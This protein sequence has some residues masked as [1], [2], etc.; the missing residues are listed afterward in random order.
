[1]LWLAILFALVA[2]L[3]ALVGFGGG[4]SYNALLI[5]AEVDYRLIPITALLCN[6]VV[7]SGGVFHFHRAGHLA[8]PTVVPFIVSSIPMSVLGGWLPISESHFIVILGLALMISGV[9]MLLPRT[10]LTRTEPGLRQRW[11]LGIPLGAGLGLLAGMVG[12][13]GGIFLAPMMYLI[14][15]APS[16]AI[17]AT[18]SAFILVNSVA[19][20]LGQSLKMAG[21][22]S[23][24][25]GRLWLLP[26]VVL[27][28]GQLSSYLGAGPV[29]QKMIRGL[30][31]VLVL[32]VAV[33]LIWQ[34]T[35]T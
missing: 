16:K 22:D 6:I 31:A 1:M 13:G 11:M 15:W 10:R 12:I 35:S 8:W 9:A 32:Y 3:Y 34:A 18:A 14:N 27:F 21:S 7:V 17:A 23:P 20:L 19:G 30:T 4:S 28:A 2:L 33:R 29:S 26:V 5:L 25:L 24:N